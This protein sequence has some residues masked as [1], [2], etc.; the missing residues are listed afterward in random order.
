[1]KKYQKTSA[2]SFNNLKYPNEICFLSFE[3]YEETLFQE[4]KHGN[5][6]FMRIGYLTPRPDKLGQG[7]FLMVYIGYEIN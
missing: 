5:N 6:I 7:F 4:F 1:M 2:S 3:S